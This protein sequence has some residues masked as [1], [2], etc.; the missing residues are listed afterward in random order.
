MDYDNDF[1]R[2]YSSITQLENKYLIKDVK[3]GHLLEMPQE[4]FML[5]PMVIFKNE[6]NRIRLI[7]DF[8]N[9]LKNDEISLPTP[10]ITGVRTR[11]KMYSSCCKI[12]MG[13]SS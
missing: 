12:K 3:T 10:V 11:L 1:N 9:A 6:K 4:T 13:D 5:I 8:Y 2:S 7:L